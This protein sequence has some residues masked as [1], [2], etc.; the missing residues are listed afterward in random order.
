MTG[1]HLAAISL[2][3][4][5]TWAAAGAG[6]KGIHI[7][8]GTDTGFAWVLTDGAGFRWDIYQGGTVNNGT[9]NAY[10]GGMNL[11][12]SGSG[13]S[14]GSRGR[15]SKDGREIEIGPWTRGSL[16][17][18]RRI[19][20]DPKLGYCR[21]IDI[22]QNIGSSDSIAAI[23]YYSNL[24]NSVQQ[25][26]TTSGKGRLTDKDWGFVSSYAGG[27]SSRPTLM[28][29]YASR[30]AKVRP[31]VQWTRGRN[32]LYYRMSLKI[33]AGKTVALCFFE[34]QRRPNAKTVALL[35][36]FKPA[37]ELAKITPAL[38]RIIVNMP[39][40][41]TS[42]GSVYLPRSEKLD[43]AVLRDGTEQLGSIVMDKYAIETFYGTIELPVG[44]VIGAYVPSGTDTQV[45]VALMDGQIVAGKLTNGPIR[46]K[47]ANGSE[48]SLPL[49]KLHTIAYRVSP[50]RPAELKSQLPMI[51]LRGGQRLRF[52][53]QD[54]NYTFHTEY[55]DLK[56][57]PGDL[58]SI[59][60]DTPEGGLHRAVFRNQSV[61]SG[62][63][64]APTFKLRLELGGTLEINRHLIREFHFAATDESPG[65]MVELTLR[66]ENVLHG[67]IVED[68]IRIKSN[69]GSPT[70]APAEIAVLEIIE[71]SHDR[72]QIKL[73]NGT[74]VRGRLTA[75]TIRFQIEPGP[76]LPIFVGHITKITCPPPS[77]PPPAKNVTPKKATTPVP[78]P[79]A[80]ADE[81]SLK[82]ALARK[83]EMEMVLAATSATLR[84]LQAGAN[85]LSAVIAK[86]P[87]NRAAAT[88]SLA[89]VRQQIAKTTK[90]IAELRRQLSRGQAP[91]KQR[92]AVQ[93]GVQR[94]A[95]LSA[96][97]KALEDRAA[98]L[99]AKIAKDPNDRRSAMLL[100]RERKLIDMTKARIA[101]VRKELAATKARQAAAKPTR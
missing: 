94:L 33:P 43:L 3:V 68:T 93:S 45:H 100:S 19:Y 40:A 16:R 50:D 95:A 20:V 61:L 42:L 54:A 11:T 51:A 25:I 15:R 89:E 55:G 46:F 59:M 73:H 1:K 18:W 5:A 67:R 53:I 85:E 4:L 86:N 32:T 76:K 13:F 63:L 74:T 84:K 14:G 78:R 17:I 29:V 28:H 36:T 80:V 26:V 88:K 58:T 9:N 35:K 81:V 65:R 69:L 72:A 23:Q 39:G 22:Y 101:K 99:A 2:V 56:L 60:L 90:R 62:L 52:N 57:D 66:N 7:T 41:F 79:K 47:L 44:R 98:D 31:T 8:D 12:V 6:D 83:A 64:V 34:A 10:G 27:S 21:W 24:G 91:L 92:S 97:L 96:G 70:I 87:A 71:G 30:G 37:R 48:M 38:R 75:K 49:A 82:K 77:K